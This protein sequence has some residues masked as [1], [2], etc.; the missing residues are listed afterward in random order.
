MGVITK[1][2]PDIALRDINE[3]VARGVLRKSGAGERSIAYGL[4]E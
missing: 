1:C 2:S 3:L 4:T